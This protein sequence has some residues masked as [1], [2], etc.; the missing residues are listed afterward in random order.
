MLLARFLDGPVKPIGQHSS[1]LK[2]LRIEQQPY[3]Q[4]SE[5]AMQQRH[6]TLLT[7]ASTQDSEDYTMRIWKH[8][9]DVKSNPASHETMH[10]IRVSFL[11]GAGFA[12]NVQTLPRTPCLSMRYRTRQ[13]RRWRKYDPRSLS[14]PCCNRR[15]LPPYIIFSVTPAHPQSLPS[16]AVGIIL[17]ACPVHKQIS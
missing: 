4:R 17:S 7:W 10:S 5:A 9:K 6:S 3:L 8:V 16:N 15:H 14:S 2:R 1:V 12:A 13:H 11:A